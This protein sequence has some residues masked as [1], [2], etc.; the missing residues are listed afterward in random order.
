MFKNLRGDFFFQSLQIFGRHDVTENI[1]LHVNFLSG[2][3]VGKNGFHHG[4]TEDSARQKLPSLCVLNAP[5][6]NLVSYRLF[7]GGIGKANGAEA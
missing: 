2:F 6:V 1:D 3:V 5:M 4:G 7:Q